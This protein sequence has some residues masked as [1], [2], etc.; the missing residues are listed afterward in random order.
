MFGFGKSKEKFRGE[1]DI[2]LNNEYQIITNNS[3]ND[4]FCGILQ[5]VE[6][7]DICQKHGFNVDES[8]MHMAVNYYCGLF[9]NNYVDEAKKLYETIER[10]VNFGLSKQMI[11]KDKW[12]HHQKIIKREQ[13]KCK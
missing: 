9:K 2:K 8:A 11:S 12:E 5:Y 7:I 1:V 13:D 4:K 10:V 6:I 3:I